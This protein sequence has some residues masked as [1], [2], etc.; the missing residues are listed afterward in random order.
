L[1]LSSVASKCNLSETKNQLLPKIKIR[2][3][4]YIFFEL[5][6]VIKP[7]ETYAKRLNYFKCDEVGLTKEGLFWLSL[8]WCNTDTLETKYHVGSIAEY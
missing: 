8:C 6:L 3:F 7:I 2:Y 5:T 1:I 4:H